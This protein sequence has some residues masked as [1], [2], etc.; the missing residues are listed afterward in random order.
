MVHLPIRP[1]RAARHRPFPSGLRVA[2]KVLPAAALLA[3][4]LSTAVPAHA[5]PGVLDPS[6]GL[7]GKVTTDF[8]GGSEQIVAL[9]AQPDG[10]L[11]AAGTTFDPDLAFEAHFALARYNPDGTLDGSF[12]S[13]GK[14]TTEVSSAIAA[15]DRANALALQPDGK[16]VV[17]G[18]AVNAPSAQDIALV[19]YN[20]DGSLDAAFGT[21]GIVTTD[22][23]GS[24]Q[25]NALALQPDGKL[26]VAGSADKGTTGQDFALV[27]YNAD[28][29]LDTTFASGGV[30][31]TDLAGSDDIALAL[32]VQADGRLVAAGTATNPD[33]L[34]FA[35]VRY[36][37]EGSL[38]AGFGVGGKVTTEV[39]GTL[40]VATALVIQGNGKL[41]AAGQ[42]IGADGSSDFDL[43]RYRPD[44]SLDTGFGVGGKVTT[45]FGG[46]SDTARALALQPNGRLLAAGIAQSASGPAD[47]AVARYRPDGSLDLTFGAGGKTTTDFGGGEFAFALAVQADGRVV[48][49][50]GALPDAAPSA[51]FALARYRAR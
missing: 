18:S 12:G 14:V 40:D 6:F 20:A 36:N 51:D 33:G 39:A 31:M 43:V 47:F 5:R 48:L 32:A 24:D 15:D 2:V 7:G 49:G 37:A 11:V 23:G 30:A 29:S 28:G 46:G 17:A 50:G 22:L 34:D 13:G 45:D 44:G 35:L 4:Q 8:A 10:K 41:V 42:A 1:E 3:V 26:V 27:R 19:R 25:A 16:L 21:G 38:D 9:V